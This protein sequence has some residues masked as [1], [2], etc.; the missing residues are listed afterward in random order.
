[1]SSML[2]PPRWMLYGI[3]LHLLNFAESETIIATTS[4]F[5]N[6]TIACEEARSCIIYC[7]QERSCMNAHILC[8]D[9]QACIISC[10]IASYACHGA[11][12]DARLSSLLE[13]NDCHS[14]DDSTCSAMAI[15]FPPNRN[16]E[17]VSFLNTGDNMRQWLHFYAIYGWIDIDTSGFVGERGSFIGEMHCS[18]WYQQH[19]P[20]DSEHLSCADAD[21]VCNAPHITDGHAISTTSISVATGNLLVQEPLGLSSD[22]QL[23]TESMWYVVV[24]VMGYLCCCSLVAMFWINRHLQR[25]YNQVVELTAR[26]NRS[27]SKHTLG[28]TSGATAGAESK[29]T[30]K[31]R[32]QKKP[33]ILSMDGDGGED[34]TLQ[35]HH[36]P[37][38]A[39]TIPTPLHHHLRHNRPRGASNTKYTTIHDQEPMQL[40]MEHDHD[41][42][43]EPERLPPEE[44]HQSLVP[45]STMDKPRRVTIPTERTGPRDA[46]RDRT[47]NLR[48]NQQLQIPTF[49]RGPTVTMQSLAA[50]SKVVHCGSDAASHLTTVCDST[51]T[52]TTC[53]ATNNTMPDSVNSCSCTACHSKRMFAENTGGLPHGLPHSTRTGDI[54]TAVEAADLTVTT[55]T[56]ATISPSSQ[57]TPSQGYEKTVICQTSSAMLSSE[58]TTNGASGHSS[59][60]RTA[61]RVSTLHPMSNDSWLT[62]HPHGRRSK[63]TISRERSSGRSGYRRSSSREWSEH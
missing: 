26:K 61:V 8:P 52:Q 31:R 1:M 9:D 7:E 21:D 63:Y 24:A 40:Q 53:T 3:L 56:T 20:F 23:S 15:Y 33:H 43:N 19:C 51:R 47:L 38:S 62:H 5:E 28:H 17:K 22:G 10:G 60:N 58:T 48:S 34:H 36:Q 59:M 32:K 50:A 2:V 35:T 54:H 14:G 25:K 49:R 29:H 42:E 27:R 55:A 45:R 57:T 12:I 30:S 16:G 11:V 37:H 13:L 4:E 39:Q 41:S 18:F 44:A 46:L 6:G